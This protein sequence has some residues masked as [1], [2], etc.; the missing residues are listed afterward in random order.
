MEGTGRAL[1]PIVSVLWVSKI[2]QKP[3]KKTG[4]IIIFLPIFINYS[5][6]RTNTT[7]GNPV[8]V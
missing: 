5:Q 4:I 2:H 1:R 6:I 7:G 3:E 8:F